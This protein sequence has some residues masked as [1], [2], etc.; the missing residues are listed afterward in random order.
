MSIFFRSFFSVFLIL[1]VVFVLNAQNYEIDNTFNSN[2]GGG[3]SGGIP[4]FILKDSNGKLIIAGDFTSYNGTNREGLVRLNADGSLDNGFADLSATFSGTTITDIEIDENDNLYVSGDFSGELIKI[5]NTG[6]I[7]GTFAFS[8]TNLT[9]GG[10]IQEIALDI[11]ANSIYIGQEVSSSVELA[12]HDLQTG[13]E[14]ASFP[15]RKLEYTST[16][17]VKDIVVDEINNSVYIAG[18]FNNIVSSIYSPV[19]IARFKES[20]GSFDQNFVPNYSQ[21]IISASSIEKVVIDPTTFDVFTIQP[22]SSPGF[23]LVHYNQNATHQKDDFISA[24]NQISDLSINSSS[25]TAAGEFGLVNL[26]KNDFSVIDNIAGNGFE[27]SLSSNVEGVLYDDS[28]DI[29]YTIGGFDIYAGTTAN[30]IAK[31]EDCNSITI[32]QQPTDKS[33]CVGESVQFTIEAIG[34]NLSYQWQENDNNGEGLY[35]D[36]VEG[37]KFSNTAT[38]TLTIDNVDFAEGHRYRVIISDADCNR[39]SADVR[40]FVAENSTFDASPTDVTACQNED[41]IEFTFT[42]SGNTQ[43]LQW[44]VKSAGDQSFVDLNNSITYTGANSFTLQVDNVSIDMDG[45]QYRVIAGGCETEVISDAATLTVEPSPEFSIEEGSEVSLCDSGDTSFTATSEN[46]NLTY[47]WQIYNINTTSYEDLA[48]GGIYS[49][50]NTATLEITGADNTMDHINTSGVVFY[51]CIATNSSTNCEGE[52]STRLVI[53]DSEPSRSRITQQ[54][55]DVMECDNTG[56]G[57]SIGFSLTAD[58]KIGEK[59]QWQVDSVD[60]NGF[61]D[62]EEQNNSTLIF[63]AEKEYSGLRYRAVVLPCGESS[64]TVRAIIDELP[65]VTISEDVEACENTESLFV[66]EADQPNVSYQWQYFGSSSYVD[67]T[68]DNSHA[69]VNNDTLVVTNNSG[70]MNRLYR[71]VV[72]TENGLCEKASQDARLIIYSDPSFRASDNTG[73]L[74]ICENGDYGIFR[75]SL[76]NT[77]GINANFFQYQWQMSREGTSFSDVTNNEFYSGASTRLL[78]IDSAANSLDSNYY[79]LVIR[80]CENEF[81]SDTSQLFIEKMPVIISQP[82]SQT[83]CYNEGEDAVFAVEAEGDNLTYQWEM[84]STVDGSYSSFLG[85][86]T[87]KLANDDYSNIEYSG[88]YFRVVVTNGSSCNQTITSAPSQFVMNEVTILSDPRSESEILNSTVCIND[89]TYV[90][91]ETKGASLNYQWQIDLG[92]GFSNLVTDDLYSSINDDTLRFLVTNENIDADYRCVVSGLCEPVISSIINISNSVVESDVPIIE[93]NRLSNGE[94]ELFVQN[95]AYNSLIWYDEEGNELSTAQRPIVNSTGIYTVEAI[96]GDCGFL[97]DPY[98]VTET[99]LS[100]KD[101]F[102]TRLYPNPVEN[103]LTVE[104]GDMHDN[105][106]TIMV[107]DA[108]GVLIQIKKSNMQ[109][110]SVDVGSLDNGMYFVLLKNKKGV[111]KRKFLKE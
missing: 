103:Q 50:V 44:Q 48:N 101:A 28:N 20:D 74:T 68:E 57:R 8:R 25:M 52:N 86:D 7:D 66:A 96:I 15:V 104:L 27:S 97:S 21:Y 18:R 65:E 14:N 45:N 84:A 59:L 78:N 105:N 33:K 3:F 16:A 111:V 11:G 34:T 90:F 82:I 46:A 71:C 69:G 91:V 5:D 102:S 64:D 94:L 110:I 83:I 9:A 19:N 81:Y 36:L 22:S 29:Y 92:D 95:I 62:L 37:G 107:Y 100:V 23:I 12:Q 109:N 67:L 75:R 61:I 72:T 108:Q 88:N 53:V 32:E 43:N 93:S 42:L 41:G 54:P 30:T 49:G 24:S 31:L 40:L 4:Q 38:N 17:Y 87:L 58:L 47:R 2:V 98:E 60:G 70:A 76:N 79:R 89:E 56:M 55:N 10:A 80:G 39:T 99:I 85:G 63:T 1:N 73:D 77:D 6:A 26:N 13:A 106:T 51:K 35:T